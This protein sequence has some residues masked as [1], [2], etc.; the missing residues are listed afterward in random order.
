MNKFN[1]GD[2]VW[3]K[4]DSYGRKA[5]RLGTIRD[6]INVGDGWCY[7]IETSDHKHWNI[8]E[9]DIN[10]SA[11][12]TRDYNYNR[13]NEEKE[14]KEDEETLKDFMNRIYGK[15]DFIQPFELGDLVIY[16]DASKPEVF[17]VIEI[18]EYKNSIG[19]M[20]SYSY[21]IKRTAR[22]GQNIVNL[23]DHDKLEKVEK[24]YRGGYIY[25]VG[26]RVRFKFGK[27]ELIGYIQERYQDGRIFCEELDR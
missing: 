24:Q 14:L 9:K 5:E 4:L 23:V 6:S 11:P 18:I 1:I 3:F 20:V 15:S 21:R 25:P 13:K 8:K 19:D 26:A 10:Y 7:N 12:H 2:K 17:T 27:N 16:K 22:D